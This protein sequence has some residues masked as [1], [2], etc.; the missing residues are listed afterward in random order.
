[1]L[2]VPHRDGDLHAIDELLVDLVAVALYWRVSMGG[3]FLGAMGDKR[4][5]GFLRW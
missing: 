5:F 3:V 4:I 1:M 2:R